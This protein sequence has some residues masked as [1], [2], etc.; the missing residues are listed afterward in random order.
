MSCLGL[1][2]IARYSDCDFLLVLLRL[3]QFWLRGL[4]QLLLKLL[5]RPLRTLRLRQRVPPA[6]V[7]IA[8]GVSGSRIRAPACTKASRQRRP[9][10]AFHFWKR[11]GRHI[12]RHMRACTMAACMTAHARGQTWFRPSNA[13]AMCVFVTCTTQGTAPTTTR[14]RTACSQ[15]G[16]FATHNS[17]HELAKPLR[18]AGTCDACW[19]YQPSK[20][21]IA[22]WACEP[23]VC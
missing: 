18:D 19:A 12:S 11:R 20:P 6:L 13:L 15:R 1:E 8:Q 2:R 22:A 17:A 23:K 16:P 21:T 5:V 14:E 10:R 9:N 3:L 4:P 7:N